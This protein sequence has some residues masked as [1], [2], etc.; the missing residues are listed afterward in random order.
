MEPVPASR[1]RVTQW[2]TYHA[3]P[4]KAW[5]AEAGKHLAAETYRAPEGHLI[6][7]VEVVCTRAKTS[8][9][10]TPKG[11]VDNYAKAI[12]DAL[13]HAGVWS[14]DKWIVKLTVVKRF[15]DPG[16]TARTIVEITA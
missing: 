15:A 4:Y 16:E 5:L 1:P 13:T 7:K 11:D 2:G 9:L 12:L 6:V 14:D 3:K 8:K 10:T